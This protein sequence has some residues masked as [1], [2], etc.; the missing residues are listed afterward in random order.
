MLSDEMTHDNF[1]FVEDM[2]Q[3]MYFFLAKA[4]ASD[5]ANNAQVTVGLENIGKNPVTTEQN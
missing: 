5:N 4:Q 2:S 3:P 1:D